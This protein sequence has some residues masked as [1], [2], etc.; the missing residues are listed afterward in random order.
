[1]ND[2]IRVRPA[3]VQ[4]V[5]FARWA[6]SQVPKVR[7]VSQ[8]E[9]GVPPV[10]FVDM[11]EGILR[12]STVD[13]RPYVSPLDHEEE[14]EPAGPGASELLGVARPVPGSPRL[15]DCG[16][17]YEEDGEEVHPH[18]ECPLSGLREAVPCQPLPEVPASAYLPDSHPLP[19]DFAPLDDAD[20]EWELSGVLVG[21]TGPETYVPLG[22]TGGDTPGDVL[23]QGGD[24]AEGTPAVTSEDTPGDTGDTA[25][26]TGGDTGRPFRCGACPRAFK[27]ERGRDS[28]RRQVHGR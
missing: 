20:G 4:R 9:F 22:D 3:A 13:G 11:P 19:A 12:G 2:F 8:S 10:L 24:T 17:C 5:A 21:E 28:H 25:R 15:L 27:S 16:L 7:T 14:T 1:M 26:D 18:P 6:V 23:T